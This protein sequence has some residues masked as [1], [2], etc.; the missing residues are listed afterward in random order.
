LR[1]SGRR[2]ALKTGGASGKCMLAHAWQR[3]HT[4]KAW[5]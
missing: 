1:L 5:W 3:P 2:Q 4:R